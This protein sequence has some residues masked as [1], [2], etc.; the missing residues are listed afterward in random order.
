MKKPFYGLLAGAVL[1]ISGTVQ[2]ISLNGQAGKKFTNL[3]V[4]LGAESSGLYSSLNWAHSDHDGDIIGLG[5]GVGAPLGSLMLS[6]GGKAMYLNPSQ[7]NG[8]SDNY[9]V[10][11]GGGLR[12]PLGQSFAL[13]GSVWYA[14][15]SLSGGIKDYT[16]ATG[17]VRWTVLRPLSIDAGYRYLKLAGKDGQR[18]NAI[19]DG[20]YVGVGVSF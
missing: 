7:S 15:D 10:A 1:L 8:G 18:D 17:G 20:P 3:E 13:Y 11:I 16:E 2:A 14:P 4:S 12:L 19:A 5:L 6:A 9:A